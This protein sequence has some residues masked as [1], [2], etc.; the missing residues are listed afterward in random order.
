M[1]G[2]VSSAIA[3]AP[4]LSFALKLIE[5]QWVRSRFC[6]RNEKFL[7]TTLKRELLTCSP[8]RL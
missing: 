8:D 6:A 7:R 5:L 3:I 4:Y 2:N 1:S